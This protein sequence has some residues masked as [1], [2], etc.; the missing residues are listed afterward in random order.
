[1]GDLGGITGTGDDTVD[2]T[3]TGITSAFT[4]ATTALNG[5]TPVAGGV[6][7]PTA[8]SAINGLSGALVVS[9]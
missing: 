3:L 7:N 6:L 1:M 5:L 8:S 4:T 2:S 9:K